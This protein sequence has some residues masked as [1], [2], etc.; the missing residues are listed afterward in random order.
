[1]LLAGDLGGTKTQL[2]LFAPAS[3]RPRL[4]AAQEYATLAFEDLPSMIS[5]FLEA[6]AATASTVTAACIGVAGPVHGEAA[7]MTNVPWRVDARAVRT[8]VGLARVTLINDVEALVHAVP[9]LEPGELATLHDA[10]PD[11]HGNAGVITVG[12]G[13]G[14]GF[15]HRVNGRV[16]PLP[17]EGGHADFPARTPRELELVAWLAARHHRVDVE[18]VVSGRGLANVAEFVHD[19][20]CPVVGDD[21]DPDLPAAISR[22]ALDGRCGRCREALDLVVGAL[23]AAAGNAAILAVAR[24]GV[25]IGGGIPAKILAALQGPV[26]R[27]AYLDKAPLDDLV[28]AIPVYAVLHPAAGLL[29]AA[30]CAQGG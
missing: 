29:G 26:F 25:F 18:R 24:A 20:T 19:G 8:G 21:G 27:G 11:P 15:L 12:T 3:P 1:M 10:V 22:A 13:F 6:H 28:A 7:D 30:A 17:S 23:G 14:Q 5:E 2:G 4:V 16:V 9:L